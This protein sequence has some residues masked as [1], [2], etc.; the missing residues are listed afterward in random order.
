MTSQDEASRGMVDVLTMA[1]KQQKVDVHDGQSDYVQGLITSSLSMLLIVCGGIHNH[2]LQISVPVRL[3]TSHRSQRSLFCKL[4][5]N[6]CSV[7]LAEFSCLTTFSFS[8]SC[9]QQKQPM[10]N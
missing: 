6:A 10:W 8:P 5:G 4:F 7:Y 1:C 2:C 9:W 3:Q